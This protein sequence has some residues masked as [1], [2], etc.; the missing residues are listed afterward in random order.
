MVCHENPVRASPRR[1]RNF[2]GCSAESL[3]YAEDRNRRSALPVLQRGDSGGDRRALLEAIFQQTRH[4]RNGLLHAPA[5]ST[6]GCLSSGPP[7][8]RFGGVLTRAEW[9]GVVDFTKE[10]DGR[11][12]TSFSTG[13]GRARFRRGVD[14]GA[15]TPPAVS[16]LFGPV[17]CVDCHFV[18]GVT[19]GKSRAAVGQ[20]A[21]ADQV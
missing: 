9:K 15:I 14:A 2:G 6:R 19:R 7:P 17:G 13:H 20:E 12:V 8:G 3:H 10:V 1:S 21:K 16:A 11:I 5:E 18:D 4:S